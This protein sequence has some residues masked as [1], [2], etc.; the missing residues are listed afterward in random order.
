MREALEIPET[1]LFIPVM[2][3]ISSLK[4]IRSAERFEM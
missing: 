2:A 3:S 1:L 4:L